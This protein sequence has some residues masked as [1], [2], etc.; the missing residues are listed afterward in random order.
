M[1]AVTAEHLREFLGREWDEARR[2]KDVGTALYV[3]S[4]GVAAALRLAESLAELAPTTS[5]RTLR[6]DVPGLLALTA[7]LDRAARRRR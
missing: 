1:G 3:R 5:R 7:K 4:R 2:R 6:N